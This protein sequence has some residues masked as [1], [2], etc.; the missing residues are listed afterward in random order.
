[1][2]TGK[3]GALTGLEIAGPLGG[4]AGFEIGQTQQAAEERE[5]QLRRQQTQLRLQQMQSQLNRLD[6]LER[7]NA[8]NAVETVSRNV[9]PSS[10]TFANV[11]EQ[12]FERAAEDEQ[13]ESLNVQLEQLSLEEKIRQA[14]R[15]R[16][17]SLLNSFENFAEIGAEI[18][19]A[20]L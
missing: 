17:A 5:R 9:S 19:F 7:M 2:S 6:K 12:N 14:K 15:R 1:M 8:A 13:A 4:L 11:T 20:L 3:G 16:D 18:G 10:G